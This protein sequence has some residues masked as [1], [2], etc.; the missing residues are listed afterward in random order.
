MKL[1]KKLALSAFGCCA[2]IAPAAAQSPPVPASS[3]AVEADSPE[4]QVEEAAAFFLLDALKARNTLR[5]QGL[6]SRAERL[7][8]S[9]SSF[10][11][12]VDDAD[13]DDAPMFLPIIDGLRRSMSETIPA[14]AAID[15][16]RLQGLLATID[17]Q[18][19]IY[20]S[21]GAFPGSKGKI[22]VTVRALRNGRAVNGLYVALDLTGAVPSGS[23]ANT[24]LKT[25]SPTT[26]AVG[27][28]KYLV[29]LMNGTTEVAR[30]E[31]RIG[32]SGTREAIDMV[33]TP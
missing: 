29:R 17:D 10:A 13:V 14:S 32:K 15:N 12:I 28:G 23:S 9:V 27:P 5:D 16:D 31:L 3:A 11:A 26:G 7:W 24:L 25:T 1:H 22:D 21:P 6:D 20:E 19:D 4:T 18:V 2:L 8:S 30:R 33:I